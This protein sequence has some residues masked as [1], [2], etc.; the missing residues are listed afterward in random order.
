MLDSAF[1]PLQELR[2]LDY[3]QRPLEVTD[4]GPEPNSADLGKFP[5]NFLIIPG[6][7]ACSS[8]GFAAL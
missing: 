2:D 7:A 6:L 8:A 4:T 1:L 3:D 5:D